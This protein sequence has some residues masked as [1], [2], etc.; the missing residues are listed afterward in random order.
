MVEIDSPTHV[1]TLLH[2]ASIT[3]A[4]DTTYRFRQHGSKLPGT[5]RYLWQPVLG[6][7]D[8]LTPGSRVLDAGC[9]NGTFSQELAR[10]GFEVCGFDLSQDGVKNARSLET[11]GRFELAS[12]YDNLLDLFGGPFD[13]IVSMEVVEHLYDPPTFARRL[14]EAL[15]PGGRL[16]ISAP[17]HGWLKNCAVAIG[18]LHDKH[19]N[20]L[21]VGGHIKFWSRQTLTKLLNGAGF[22]VERFRGA[23]RYPYLWKSLIL[24]ARKS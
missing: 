12:A 20:P 6:E 9:G 15:K 13:A 10:R 19:F 21:T 4:P 23:G 24:T 2:T 5:W 17:Y 8:G 22:E 14:S 1:M 7:L 16:V 11:G 18:G 3:A